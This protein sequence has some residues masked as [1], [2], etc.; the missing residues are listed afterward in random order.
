MGL[1][2]L[3]G[4]LVFG[5][6]ALIL[7]LLGRHQKNRLRSRQFLI[8]SVGVG[9]LG[10]VITIAG[11]GVLGSFLVRKFYLE[12]RYCHILMSIIP[13]NQQIQFLQNIISINNI[14][15][16]SS[17]YA[18]SWNTLAFSYGFS[19]TTQP[20]PSGLFQI[21]YSTTTYTVYY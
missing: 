3:V 8:A 16:I 18:S 20:G 7:A 12:G 10:I 14:K 4:N 11:W 2:I 13:S 9:A 6:V 1:S 19:Y 17:C 15:Q 5:P 21:I